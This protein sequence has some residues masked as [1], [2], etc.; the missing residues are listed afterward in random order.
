LKSFMSEPEEFLQA[1]TT[2][3]AVI[4]GEVALAF[5]LR[6]A[7]FPTRTLEIFAV[8]TQ[9]HL[10]LDFF[11]YSSS[12]LIRFALETIALPSVKFSAQRDI[13]R[14][15]VFH[16]STQRTIY[17]YESTTMSPCAPIVRSWTGAL[18]NFV[19][20]TSF[21]C[22]TPRLTLRRRGLVSDL[23]LSTLTTRDLQIM[24][25]M[26]QY[27]FTFGTAASRWTDYRRPDRHTPPGIVPCMRDLYICPDQGRYF[28]DGGSLVDFVDPLSP[29]IHAV[30][31]ARLPPFGHMVA[32]RMWCTV[33]CSFGCVRHDE[34]LPEGVI[35]MDLMLVDN[36]V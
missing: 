21:G 27:G 15:A 12:S 4:G 20:A 1:L 22:A 14:F 7:T 2:S 8:D 31:S 18:M 36:P 9:F 11:S 13:A 25:R 34:L 10:L 30:H 19:T 28:G 17:V 29:A 32:W 26:L 5:F 35:A 3:G 16:T 23:G 6:D 24:G 33:S